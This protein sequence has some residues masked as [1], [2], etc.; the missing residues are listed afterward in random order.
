MQKA[1]AAE[2]TGEK[3]VEVPP[4]APGRRK[5][6]KSQVIGWLIFGLACG[7]SIPFSI[8][9]SGAALEEGLMISEAWGILHG[10]T[11]YKSYNFMYG[12]G[13]L[14]LLAG[15]WSVF[16]TSLWSERALGDVVAAAIV[17][18]T[19][20]AFSLA[21]K[22][23]ALTGAFLALAFVDTGIVAFPYPWPLHMAIAASFACLVLLE[24]A[25]RAQP[26]TRR[27][28]WLLIA[29]GSLAFLALWVRFDFA[30]VLAPASVPYAIRLRRDFLVAAGVA[31][32]ATLLAY[33][34]QVVD[35]GW[36]PTLYQLVVNPQREAPGNRLPIPPP[37]DYLAGYFD[38]G[39]A[40]FNSFPWPLPA[41]SYPL[42]LDLLFFLDMGLIAFSAARSLQLARRRHPLWPLVASFSLLSLG[43][44]PSTLQRDDATHLIELLFPSL[45]AAFLAM[46]TLG[47][48][49]TRSRWVRFAAQGGVVALIVLGAPEWVSSQIVANVSGALGAPYNRS[50]VVSNLGHQFTV[51][52]PQLAAS[53]KA[54]LKLL[55]TIARPGQTVFVGN[56]DVRF[57][58]YSD[59][60]LYYMLPQLKPSTY[61]VIL[62]PDISLH[63][64]KRYVL[65][66]SRADFLLLDSTYSGFA[67]PN[68]SRML[69]PEVEERAVRDHF[70][71]V[72]SYGAFTVYV[73]RYNR[74]TRSLASRYCNRPE[75]Q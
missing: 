33:A 11:I 53:M 7:V 31:M 72:A 29:A 39:H 75:A 8:L 47:G 69:G 28:R 58:P 27:R 23:R 74:D 12:P 3:T 57:T 4:E 40:T 68:E 1:Q 19:S 59:V 24:K 66:I 65:E 38:R 22:G 56:S 49:T 21:G 54:S 60:E 64:V 46:G 10:A 35:S 34:A 62:Y 26:G 71:Q 13:G 55:D 67:E 30:L 37:P 61:F 42:Q 5:L 15:W 18:A 2:V 51:G 44:V 32:T 50:Y 63:H 6:P 73:N 48:T 9:H 45:V 14:W 36:G 16:G 41:P 17:A 70:C 20:L 25:S 43:F 52:D